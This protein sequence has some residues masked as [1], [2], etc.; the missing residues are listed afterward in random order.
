MDEFA[1]GSG[2]DPQR[3]AAEAAGRGF[4]FVLNPR[5]PK[6]TPGGSSSG[7]AA[8]VAAK[9]VP[10]ALGSDTGGSVR[11]PAACCGVVGYKP[12]LGMVPR[13][14]LFA[15]AGSFDQIG[16][17]ARTV[18][19][20]AL[21]ADAIIQAQPAQINCALLR[22]SFD[23]KGRKIGVLKECYGPCID[24]AAEIYKSLGAEIV[25][26]SVPLIEQC[27][28]IYSIIAYCEASSNFSIY[29]GVRFGHRTEEAGD[30]DSLYINSRTEGFGAEV[31]RRIWLGTYMLSAGKYEL[32]YKKAR[33]AQKMLCEQFDRVFSCCEVLLSPVYMPDGITDKYTVPASIAG[34]PAIAVGNTQLIGKRFDDAALLGFARTFEQNGGGLE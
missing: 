26:V 4:G 25:E 24:S 30:I 21:L 11:L 19:D 3:M 34:L 12:G 20:A 8:A 14:G 9:S 10:L 15:Y 7:S 1:M 5:D 29:D 32:Y 28:S 6:R 17:M 2:C 33:I 23:V 27:L 13:D 18:A 16:P 31:R 22:S